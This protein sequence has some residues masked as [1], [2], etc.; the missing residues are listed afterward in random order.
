MVRLLIF[1]YAAAG[2]GHLRVTG[3]LVSGRPRNHSYELLGTSDPMVTKIHR[4]TSINP[5]AKKI[6]EAFQY[7]LL[8]D[9]FTKAYVWYLRHNTKEVYER[10]LHMIEEKPDA[11]GVTIVATHFGLAHQIAEIK[12]KIKRKIGKQ[13]DVV[14]QVTDDTSQHIWCIRGAD[15]TFV[16]SQ[17][18]K[19]ELEVYAK[20]QGINIHAEVSPYPTNPSF[21]KKIERSIETREEAF[22]K[23]SDRPINV[24]VPISG[25]AVGL[26]YLTKFLLELDRSSKKF[27]FWIVAKRSDQTKRFLSTIGKLRWIQLITGRSDNETVG[28][29][30]KVYRENLIHA[31][32]TKPSEQAFKALI[33]PTMIGGSVLLFTEP[34][35]RQEK[36]NIVFLKRHK[37]LV[38]DE[39]IKEK[40]TGE[41]HYPRGVLLPLDPKNAARC[42]LTCM[43][44]E[45][46]KKMTADFS[47]SP[48]SMMSSEISERGTWLFWEQLRLL[49]MI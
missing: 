20:Q 22:K 45:Y 8:E 38:E 31:E 37:L 39:D 11:E 4:L 10:V 27:H 34:I 29:Y 49:G 41:S 44:D 40:M 35:G 1:T 12:N 32:V 24:I 30:E 13:V 9:I 17:Q 18:T 46:F 3:A 48:E 5:I 7:G 43:D 2:L 23:G 25:A 21:A 42:V 19:E 47:Y 36:D 16:P 26:K 14:V 28:L 15:I 33:P 6:G